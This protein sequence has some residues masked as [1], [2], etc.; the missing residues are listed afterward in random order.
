MRNMS[1]GIHKGGMNRKIAI[2]FIGVAIVLL[3]LGAIEPV[4]A[5]WTKKAPIHINNT[6]GSAL[7]DYQVMINITY[8]SD[9]NSNFSDIRVVNETSGETVPYWI[10]NKSD[11]NWCKLWF[12][13]SYIPASSWCNDT[14]YLYYG[15]PSASSAS[16]GYT[17]FEFFNKH[18]EDG[19]YSYKKL[20]KIANSAACQGWDWCDNFAVAVHG[21]LHHPHAVYVSSQNKIFL[22][23]QGVDENWN[24]EGDPFISYFDTNTKTWATPVRIGSNPT[25]TRTSPPDEHGHPVMWIDTDGYIHVLWGGHGVDIKHAKSQSPYDISSWNESTFCSGS[26]GTYPKVFWEGNTIYV[27]RRKSSDTSSLTMRKSTDG[28]DTW[29]SDTTIV[30]NSDSESMY[31]WG[32]KKNGKIHFFGAESANR[33]RVYYFYFDIATEKCYRVDGSELTV[34]FT[35]TDLGHLYEAPEG[36]RVHFAHG[37]GDVDEDGNPHAIIEETDTTDGWDAKAQLKAFKWT[38]SGW[39]SK[40]IPKTISYRFG[41]YRLLNVK[42]SN[43]IDLYFVCY[44][45]SRRGAL[46][47]FHSSDGLNYERAEIIADDFAAVQ[48]ISPVVN[49]SG[50]CDWNAPIIIVAGCGIGEP[51]TY[52]AAYGQDCPTETTSVNWTGDTAQLTVNYTFQGRDCLRLLDENDS[53]EYQI[54][55]LAEFPEKFVLEYELASNSPAKQGCGGGATTDAWQCVVTFG[56]DSY[57]RYYYKRDAHNDFSHSNTANTWYSIAIKAK[58]FTGNVVD[59]YVD[60]VQ[61]LS[62]QPLNDRPPKIIVPTSFAPGDAYVRNIRIR[63]YADPE[64]T[65]QLGAEQNIGGGECTAPTISSLTNSTP[66]TNSVTI[67]WTTNQSA[68]NRVKYSKNPDLSDYSWSSWDNDTT[69]VSITLTGLE[70]N[71]TYYYQAWS[72]NGTNSSC[73][74]V[75][76]SSQPYKNFT[77]QQSSGSYDSSNPFLCTVLWSIPSDTAFTVTLAGTETQINFTASSKTQT[78]L[79]PSGQDASSN[80]PIITIENTGNTNLN[81]SCNLT[82]AKPSWATIKVSSQNDHTTATEFDTERAVINASVPPGQ[83]TPMYLWTN[84][85]NATG[86]ETRT[87]K[88]W[89]EVA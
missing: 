34:P 4:S 15:N 53:E 46:E 23:W 74:T 64:P 11:S 49:I 31:W 30:S 58:G 35:A 10:E 21:M 24:Y 37:G 45:T 62:N 51:N 59:V 12:N 41:G 17:T 73:Y 83:S 68:D 57:M 79:E 71:T 7:T 55:M 61:Y 89:S 66:T 80:I 22:V 2:G 82:S 18:G 87:F 75:E 69:S 16:D 81:F 67:T 78:L 50:E 5:A 27:F 47:R 48:M 29:G 42:S 1:N 86:D 28:G 19:V 6:G 77:T 65:A 56:D 26:C 3:V 88:I 72:Y 33:R 32:L 54:A 44:D 39:S 25:W 13:A 20:K 36:H 52:V 43:N 70:A 60:D 85:T 76:P 9:M 63:K 14:Y 84:I 40:D 38:G 8:D